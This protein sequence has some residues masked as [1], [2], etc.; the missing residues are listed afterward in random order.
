MLS[1]RQDKPKGHKH[2]KE[3]LEFEICFFEGVAL[4]FEALNG[5]GGA[6]TGAE[7]EQNEEPQF[8]GQY[9][10]INASPDQEQV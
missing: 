3:D 4:L 8:H 2:T 7:V 10:H 9:H 6:A 5:I 1:L